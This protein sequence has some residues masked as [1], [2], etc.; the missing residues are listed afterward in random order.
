MTREEKRPEDIERVPVLFVMLCLFVAAASCGGYEQDLGQSNDALWGKH[1]VELGYPFVGGLAGS[2]NPTTTCS[3]TQHY[4]ASFCTGSLIGSRT[5]LS[6]GHCGLNRSV[7]SVNMCNGRNPII[8]QVSGKVIEPTYV[9][10]QYSSYDVMI[11]KTK[12]VS[13]IMAKPFNT[14][15]TQIY[16]GK[17]IEFVGLGNSEQ[18]HGVLRHGVNE[19]RSVAETTYKIYPSNDPYAIANGF[20]SEGAGDSGGPGLITD[21]RGMEVVSGDW[22]GGAMQPRTD[23][24]RDFIMQASNFNALPSAPFGTLVAK[25]VRKPGTNQ[26]LYFIHGNSGL[27]L[28]TCASLPKYRWDLVLSSKWGATFVFRNRQTAKCFFTRGNGVDLY[29]STCWHPTNNMRFSIYKKYNGKY[30]FISRDE[31]LCLDSTPEQPWSELQAR[32]CS[33][34]H[35]KFEWEIIN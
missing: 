2:T 29:Q 28:G 10:N 26:C 30:M 24:F 17:H 20:A 9:A 31:D 22:R 7:K 13:G 15:A 5:V 16:K 3:S 12:T 27:S 34:T 11:L 6:A 23:A 8:T 19:I 4:M 1:H 18:G 21:A 14:D 33:L 32:P 25:R 35:P